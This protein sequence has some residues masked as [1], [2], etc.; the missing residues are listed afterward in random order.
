MA[1]TASPVDRSGTAEAAAGAEPVRGGHVLLVDDEEPLLFL[2]SRLLGRLGHRVT[3][4]ASPSE[5][6]EAFRSRPG[7]FDLVVTDVTMPGMSGFDLAGSVLAVRP[8]MPVV[9]TSGCVRPEDEERA[10]R[11]G[12]RAVIAKPNTM[13]ELARTLDAIFRGLPG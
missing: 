2:A 4:F 3:T 9:I 8:G 1:G 7:A 13:D 6:L 10:A 11:I 12:V 5:A